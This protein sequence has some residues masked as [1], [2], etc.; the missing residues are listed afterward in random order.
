MQQFFQKIENSLFDISREKDMDGRHVTKRKL[1]FDIFDN[2]LTCCG[3]GNCPILEEKYIWYL[4]DISIN[5]YVNERAYYYSVDNIGKNDE[6]RYCI[7]NEGI[8]KVL[9][10][11]ATNI[12]LDK[13]IFKVDA[14]QTR[15]DFKESSRNRKAYWEYLTKKEGGEKSKPSCNYCNACCFLESQASFEEELE[16]IIYRELLIK[17]KDKANAIDLFRLCHIRRMEL[18]IT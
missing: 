6:N 16:S 2:L 14:C 17:N 1:S 10:C 4:S 5:H 8:D 13:N 12:T 15:N 3:N 9:S 11:C 18:E 7:A